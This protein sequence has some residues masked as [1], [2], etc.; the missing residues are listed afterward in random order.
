MFSIAAKQDH[1]NRC[2]WLTTN[3]KLDWP[4]NSHILILDILVVRRMTTCMFK[5]SCL[6]R[7]SIWINNH[8]S[9]PNLQCAILHYSN[10]KPQHRKPWNGCYRM[11]SSLCTAWKNWKARIRTKSNEASKSC[12]HLKAKF[13]QFP[14]SI[15]QLV[16]NS[17][18][19]HATRA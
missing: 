3:C 4:N 13:L 6:H 9:L 5:K 7:L 16:A 10:K 15:K 14:N 11:R 1:K 8:A 19:Y 2:A 18:H 17:K 12:T